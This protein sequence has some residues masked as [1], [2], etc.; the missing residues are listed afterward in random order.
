MSKSDKMSKW[1]ERVENPLERPRRRQVTYICSYIIQIWRN[2]P[3]ETGLRWWWSKLHT[4]EQP[5]KCFSNFIDMHVILYFSF[6][7]IQA[8]QSHLLRLWRNE[9]KGHW[10]N[11]WLSIV[12]FRPA[13]FRGEV[14]VQLVSSVIERC[15]A[16]QLCPFLLQFMPWESIFVSF[17]S[18][19]Y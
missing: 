6:P 1:Q 17:K 11:A 2:S 4:T 13:T 3:A 9:P 10:S 15:G 14:Y 18:Q 19:L 7:A 5:G 8:A 16:N 12:Q